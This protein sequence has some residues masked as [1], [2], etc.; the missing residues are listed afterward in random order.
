MKKCLEY[1][2]SILERLQPY[3]LAKRLSTVPT[4]PC[5]PC[6]PLRTMQSF[7]RFAQRAFRPSTRAAFNAGT[8]R[9]L[10]AGAQQSRKAGGWR[11][12]KQLCAVCVSYLSRS[13]SPHVTFQEGGACVGVRACD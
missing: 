3:A 6:H 9:M 10:T 13:F 11:S 12:C 2:H 5:V 8:K 4:V 7:S 1:P